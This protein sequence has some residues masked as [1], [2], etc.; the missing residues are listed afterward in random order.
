VALAERLRER[1]AREGPISFRDFMAAALY[2]PQEG[3][4]ATGARIGERGD[5]VTSPTVSPLFAAALARRFSRDV[6]AFEGE[7]D[8]V[9]VGAGS[10]QFLADFAAAL[11][12]ASPETAA[13]LR[14]TAIERSA[15][16]RKA[17]SD[18]AIEPAPR[19]LES[20]D[21]LLPRTVSGWIFSNEL[22]DA[23]PVVRVIRGAEELE[24]LRVSREGDS[25]AW[26]R[27]PAPEA[28]REHLESFGIELAPGQ[29]AEISFGAAPLHRRLARALAR[30]WMLAFDYGHRAPVL[31]HPV[32]RRAGTLVVHFA[33]LRRGDPLVHP[34]QV[35]LTAHVNWDLLIRAGEEEGLTGSRVVRQGRFLLELGIFDLVT[36]SQDKWKA[37]RLVD[38]EGMGE[39]LSVLVQSRGIESTEATVEKSNHRI[40]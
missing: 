10:G 16:G 7:V 3:Y 26:S 39:E 17:I 12:A 25:F 40:N 13:R 35:D 19:V 18:R 23:L 15:A 33:G 30:G 20:A 11:A 37:Y 22:Y 2:D 29:I 21:A 24:E 14:L 32:A 34:G 4:Y 1:I 9:E 31:Y 6:A 5:F 28:V 8:F 27:A 38:P 36:T